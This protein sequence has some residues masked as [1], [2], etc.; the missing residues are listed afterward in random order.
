MKIYRSSG[1]LMHISSLPSKFGIGDFGPSAYEFAELLKKNKQYYW[2]ILP[3]N[4]TE[5]KH[6]NSPYFSYSAFAG[7]PLF[8]SPV[9]LY[10]DGLLNKDD[11]KDYHL[12]EGIYI[13]FPK[14]YPLK[15]KMLVKACENFN[16]K[17]KFQHEFEK[18]F[19]EQSFWLDDYALFEVLRSQFPDQKWNQWPTW[20]SK[21]KGDALK[22]VSKKMKIE[23]KNQKIIQ[24]LFYRQWNKLKNFCKENEIKI[25]GDMPI[26]VTYNSAD[27]WSNPELF[28]LD[29][30]NSP[31]F[32]AGVPPDYFSKT[33]QLWGNPVY[34]WPAHRRE[35]FHW[36]KDRISHNL[37]TVDLLR[38]DHFRGL[39]A[40][41]EVPACA[42]TA[43]KGKWVTGGGNKFFKMLKQNYPNLPFIAEDL[44][45]ITED[46]V[47]II[48]NLGLPGMR[49]LQFGFDE[50]NFP[51]NMHLPHDYSKNCVAYTGTHDNNTIQAWLQ[52]D[53]CKKQKR[54]LRKYMGKNFQLKNAH[55]E[56]IRMIMASVAQLA[57]IP[58][59]DILGL[60]EEARMN[61]P[62][63]TDSN[64]QWHLTS[65][66][67]LEIKEHAL[68]KLKALTK[69]YAREKLKE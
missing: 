47:R 20:I 56:L 67:M 17:T 43:I 46:V 13:D 44:G 19:Q 11:L 3:L 4:P 48:D 29:E 5:L 63:H 18:F 69:I 66:D 6:G 16:R 21:H 40:Y 34:K 61:Y 14:V 45:V 35:D 9:L 58:V 59:Q 36:W 54:L 24:F 8:I 51:Y 25:I 1:L 52:K 68:P 62:S 31:S 65:K 50:K 39:V 60:G 7:N 27:V 30:N 26:Y 15:E 37:A 42:K 49:V 53:I 10:Q 28:K 64:W 38:I 57:I 41:W 12:P 33:G 32:V 55:W 22:S 23:I 2:Q